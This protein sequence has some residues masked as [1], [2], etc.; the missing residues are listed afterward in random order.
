MTKH[1]LKDRLVKYNSSLEK[2]EKTEWGFLK[3]VVILNT[4]LLQL[5]DLR[6]GQ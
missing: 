5:K 2:P 4:S 1:I 6:V 3:V